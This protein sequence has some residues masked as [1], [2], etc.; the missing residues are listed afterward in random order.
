MALPSSGLISL[1]QVNT[2]L[3]KSA[4]A[5]ISL[6]DSNVRKLAG[7]TTGTINMSDLRGKKASESV[8]NY[9]LY[10]KTWPAANKDSSGS[11][12]VNLKPVVSGNLIIAMSGRYDTRRRGTFTVFSKEYSD[13]GTYTI[14]VSVGTTS[15]TI[16]YFTGNCKGSQ[17]RISGAQLTLNIKFTGEWEA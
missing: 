15:V 8:T 7:R 3:K 1:S 11:F 13:D 10:N 6:N 2:E 17:D 16:G 5:V 9:Q 12:T 4:T 14:P